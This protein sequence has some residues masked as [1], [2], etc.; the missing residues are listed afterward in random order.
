MENHGRPPGPRATDQQAARA[1]LSRSRALVLG[2]LQ[3]RPAP[4]SLTTLAGITGLHPNTVRE[5]LDALVEQGLVHR[6]RAAPRGRGRPAWLYRTSAG[7]P[8]DRPSPSTGLAVALASAL[9]RSSGDA[10]RDAIAAGAAWGQE[11]ARDRPPADAGGRGARE[12]VLELLG[13]LGFAPRI[14]AAAGTA[15][16]T[17]CP[18]LDA[19]RRHPEVV[20]AVHLGVVRGALQ[21]YGEDP[22]G[23]ELLPFSE[24]DACRLRLEATLD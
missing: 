6:E 7:D 2:T 10:R 3:S 5:H 12:E 19:A 20:C 8:T 13:E 24:P 15:D 17:R 9:A 14:D 11:L 1:A 4:S 23:T 21:A 18:L 22:D 16:L